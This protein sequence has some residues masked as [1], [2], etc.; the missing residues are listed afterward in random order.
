MIDFMILEGKYTIEEI[1]QRLNQVEPRKL[2]LE[3]RILRVK[4]HI[5]HLQQGGSAIRRQR[6]HGL[7]IKEDRQGKVS[8]DL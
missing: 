1:A 2:P 4:D 7:K 5:D 6:P 3:Q 8:F